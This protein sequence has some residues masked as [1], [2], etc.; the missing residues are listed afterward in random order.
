MMLSIDVIV[1]PFHAGVRCSQVGK[2]PHRLIE[3]GLLD[4]LRSRSRDVVV[5][6][7]EAV[8]AF[9]GEIGRTFEVKRRVASAVAAVVA[10]G[11]FPLVLAG[12]C[13]T[14][15]GVYAGL[16]NL[17]AG[18]IWFDAHSDFNT[19][20]EMTSG[21]FDGMGVA[22]LTAARIF[23]GQQRGESG[24]E[25]RLSF[26][27]FPFSALSKTYSTNQQTSDSAPTMSAIISGV[28]TDE[29]ILSVNQNVVRGDHTT[30]KGNET[31]TLLQ[32]AE[33]T[34]RS[35]GVVSTARLTHATPAACYAHSPDRDWESDKDIIDRKKEAHAA[36][37]P[38]IARQLL[39]FSYGDGLE[40]A[41]GGG[42]AKFLPNTLSDPEYDNRKGERLDGRDLSQEWLNKNRNSAFVWNKA[43]F[44]VIDV[45]K[46]NHLLGLFE[47]SQMQFEYDRSKDRSGEPSLTEMATKSVDIL[48]QNKKGFFLM[49][50]A[51]RIDHAHHN[52]NAFRA[53]SDTV[54][55]SNAVRAVVSKVNLDET[56][57]VVTADHS[58]TL[59]IQGYPMRG[60]NILGL[61]REVDDFGNPESDYK[62]DK[63]GLPFTTLGYANGRGYAG[64]SDDQ[65]EGP[66][67]C[68]AE[69]KT[70]SPY[71][72]GRYDLS[73][74]STTDPDY[75]QETDKPLASE[76]HGGED[77]A[78]F[79]T[80]VNAHLFRGSMEQN[81]IFYVMADALR[82]G[83][84]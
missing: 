33:E 39:E 80:G 68:C 8:D 9:E 64:A 4:V 17:N 24:E 78:I 49:V 69:P 81:W 53:L 18:V 31:K 77:V 28:K 16:G 26:E 27:E 7:I 11:H 61:V 41:L 36:G 71:L 65:P 1:A 38:D 48:S 72:K 35:T 55:L 75:L 12:N 19:P 40:V 79:A 25:N 66:K 32:M 59:F 21:Y 76:T 56:L 54:E 43:Q 30:V 13:N 14:S 20:E 57:I 67:K 47:P 62:R 58:H 50:E 63:L 6:E 74:I 3:A 15:V 2:G 37:F 83:R 51:G 52:G 46:T 45:K 34:G 70:F 44:D 42:R 22:T 60:N 82:V 23:E 29:G 84:K 73:N 10:S 5:I